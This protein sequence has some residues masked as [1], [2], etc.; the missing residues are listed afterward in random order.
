MGFL[1]GIVIGAV[2]SPILLRLCKVGYEALSKN[3][4]H[5]EDNHGDKKS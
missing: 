2:L 1:L 5:L 3:V 4:K